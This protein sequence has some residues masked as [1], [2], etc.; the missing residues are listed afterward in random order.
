MTSTPVNGLLNQ[1]KLDFLSQT[2]NVGKVQGSDFKDYLN[3]S[4]GQ[5]D[6]GSKQIAQKPDNNLK[7]RDKPEIK[8]TYK[9]KPTVM[10][11]ENVKTENPQKDVLDEDVKAVCDA[12]EDVKAYLE[13]ELNV[14]EEEI[15][16]VLEALQLTMAALLYPEKLPEIVAKLSDCEDTLT[17]ATDENLYETLTDLTGEVENI[18]ED[19]S[20]DLGINVDTCKRWLS[21]LQTSG[22]SSILFN[23]HL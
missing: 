7:A 9:D 14:T 15:V 20:K 11:T 22:K 21:I 6:A 1:A 2:P 23:L 4:K 8:E 10:R 19:I 13:E 16:N 5:S 18:L 3:F 17:L 12:I